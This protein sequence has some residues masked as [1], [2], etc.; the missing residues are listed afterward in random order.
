VFYEMCRKI[1]ERVNYYKEEIK[2]M[3]LMMI[4]N[5]NNDEKL[6]KTMIRIPIKE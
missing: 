5:K 4:K 3:I 2:I 1:E 6:E